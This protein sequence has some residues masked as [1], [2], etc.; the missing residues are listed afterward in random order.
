VTRDDAITITTEDGT[1]VQVGH[2]RDIVIVQGHTMTRHTLPTGI[3]AHDRRPFAFMLKPQD[4]YELVAIMAGQAY[5]SQH[6][7]EEE[8]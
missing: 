7:A 2:G 5:A 4:V 8:G 3:V 1:Q 6:I